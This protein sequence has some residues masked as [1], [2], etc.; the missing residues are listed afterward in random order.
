MPRHLVNTWA[1]AALPIG[2][3]VG[4]PLTVMVV[5]VTATATVTTTRTIDADTHRTTGTGNVILME[6]I[7]ETGG[8][9][10][11]PLPEEGIVRLRAPGA[12][13]VTAGVHPVEVAAAPRSPALLHMKVVT[14]MALQVTPMEGSGK[15]VCR[16]DI[17]KACS[18]MSCASDAN[19]RAK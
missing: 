8:I 12:D 1:I 4:N 11:V 6:G 13:A 2:V 7:T 5:T 10:V 3:M 9:G 14:P 16:L 17:L 19:G 18:R 15:P